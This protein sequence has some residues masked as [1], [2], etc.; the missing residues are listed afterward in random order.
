M[1][2]HSKKTSAVRSTPIYF[3]DGDQ[4][5]GLPAFANIR[6]RAYHTADSGSLSAHVTYIPAHTSPKKRQGLHDDDISWDFDAPTVE[7]PPVD[8]NDGLDLAYLAHNE[9]ISG[10]PPKRNRM[11]GVSKF[12]TIHVAH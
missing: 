11:A 3:D 8:I 12:L 9:E 10:L 5:K 2:K 4:P 7:A 1:T 6:H